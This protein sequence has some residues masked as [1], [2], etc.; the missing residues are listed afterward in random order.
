MS[1]DMMKMFHWCWIVVSSEESP[2][3]EELSPLT[4]LL[5]QL[6]PPPQDQRISLSAQVYS[7]SSVK[8]LSESVAV[9]SDACLCVSWSCTQ[10]HPWPASPA[11]TVWVEVV[12]T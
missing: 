9:A 1:R 7:S 3:G 6:L 10:S 8:K 11:W 12:E 5:Q 2:L 4:T